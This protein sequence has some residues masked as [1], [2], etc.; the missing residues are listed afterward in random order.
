[1]S[2]KEELQKN[3]LSI[4]KILGNCTESYQFCKYLYSPETPDEKQYIEN[5][6]YFKYIRHILWRNSVIEL[7]KL[8]SISKRRDK[9]NISHF[10]NKLRREGHFKIFQIDA[11]KIYDWESALATNKPIIDN[12]LILRDKVYAHTDVFNANESLNGLTFQEMEIL[13]YLVEDI[14]REIY[15]SVY[16]SDVDLRT[17]LFSAGNFKLINY[18]IEHKEFKAKELI[19]RLNRNK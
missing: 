5:S 14:I 8:F 19:E 13:I 1:M 18:L 12:L 6:R 17:P 9:Y 11:H 7:S 16:G 15:R 2:K 3:I 10:I 4:W